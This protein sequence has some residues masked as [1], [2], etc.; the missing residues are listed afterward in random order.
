MLGTQCVR[1]N[2]RSALL[3]VLC[4][5]LNGILSSNGMYFN[6]DKI[7]SQSNEIDPQITISLTHTIFDLLIVISFDGY[8][9]SFA[10]FGNNAMDTVPSKSDNKNSTISNSDFFPPSKDKTRVCQLIRSVLLFNC[11][12][13]LKL[14]SISN[15]HSSF[16]NDILELIRSIIMP[17]GSANRM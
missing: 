15:I 5:F 11:F 10:A 7:R 2:I 12:V 4:F 16:F 1:L 17:F 13:E 14:I 9:F 3:I 6:N 8:F